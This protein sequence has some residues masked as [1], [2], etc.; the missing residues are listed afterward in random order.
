MRQLSA[1]LARVD[2]G[3]SEVIT[4]EG[5]P[6]M[7]K[8]RLLHE[9]AK[10]AAGLGWRVVRRFG[11]E[12]EVSEPIDELS[13]EVDSPT[14]V[15]VDDAQWLDDAGLAQLR[16]AG[17]ER[18]VPRLL[19]VCAFRFSPRESVIAYR[20]ACESVGGPT[21]TLQPLNESAT[22]QF[23]TEV[24]GRELNESDIERLG[25]AGGVPGRIRD[26]Y[27]ARPGSVA[28]R[29]LL[30]PLQSPPVPLTPLI[31]REVE[32]TELLE[33][34]GRERLITLAGTGGTGKTRLAQE[35]AL[36]RSRSGSGE[37]S[38]VEL[39][40][41]NDDGVMPAIAAA[42]GVSEIEG[43]PLVEVICASMI[44]RSEV[45]VVLDNA[46][47]VLSTIASLVARLLAE[48]PGLRIVCT[49]REP[50]DIR[51]EW[52]WRVPPLRLPDSSTRNQL[53]IAGIG[54]FEAVALFVE[55]A[56]RVRRGFALTAS[57][58][59]AV[60]RICDR[61]DGLPLA[62]ELAAARVRAMSPDRIASDLETRV[63]TLVQV[64][65][66]ADDRHQTLEASI[67]WSEEL[68]D[69]IERVVFRRLGVFV[70]GFTLEAAQ[71]VVADGG[72]AQ[73]QVDPYSV[74][75]VVTRLV[76]KSLVAADDV[77]DRFFMLETIRSFATTRLEE[78][79]E[80][81]RVRDAHAAWFA[82]W[83]RG[84]DE[85]ANAND[86]QQ[87]IDLTP[88]WIQGIAPDAPNCYAAFDW[89]GLGSPLSLRLTRGLGYYWLLTASYDESMRYGLASL[90][91]GDA[92]TDEW[93]EAARWLIGTLRN[94]T[95]EGPR[96]LELAGA[97]GGAVY[98]AQARFQMTGAL[99]NHK[100]EDGPIPEELALFTE[101]RDQAFAIKDWVSFTNAVYIPSSVCAEVGLL[102]EAEA[103]LGGFV[104][105]RTLL[106]EALCASRR[107]G[108]RDATQF[109]AR[110]SDIVRLDFA[111]VIVERMEVAFTE[112]EV[113]L[114]SGGSGEGVLPIL[115][116]AQSRYVGM[117]GQLAQIIEGM[118]HTLLG[119]LASARDAFLR[120]EGSSIRIYAAMAKG[121]LAQVLMAVGATA[122]ARS[123]AESLLAQWSHMRAPFHEANGHTV[124]AECDMGERPTVA[125]DHAH[126]ALATAAESELW[127]VSID[128]LEAIGTIRLNAG[129]SIEGARL[130][131]A[132]Q[133]ERDRMGYRYRFAH[134]A[135]YVGVAQSIARPTL[136]WAE[137]TTLT[138]A[139]AIGLAQ[140]MRG[141]RVRPAAGWESL[142]PTEVQV[143]E[144]VVRG[145]SNPQVAEKLFMSR[146]TVKTHLVHI[147]DKLSV[148]NRTELAAVFRRSSS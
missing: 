122:D 3:A 38:W 43:Q 34:L 100:L 102:R 9:L 90:T 31:G 115:P 53:P 75:D 72:D 79:G 19:I 148:R 89:V 51:G 39:A 5:E 93:G 140:R 137:G 29:D 146:A 103:I 17:C 41:R 129:R 8:S 91:A 88:V 82:D 26:L 112:S 11:V 141:E 125:L 87:F 139:E 62:I 124:L 58:V 18:R 64:G 81:S 96:L 110:A 71:S 54:E 48:V 2:D 30:E 94:A 40:P 147:F 123:M 65:M 84:L 98:S 15:I 108:F 113:A 21:L 77:H 80:T 132:A 143:A 47:H 104:N 28:A 4:V 27:E 105:H 70:G 44:R 61:L 127:V 69:D 133:A 45:V 57:N 50:L 25:H 119:D 32:L 16:G 52:V 14:L 106:I 7:G 142:T 117:Y 74:T 59:A 121:W 78:S 6:G 49:S 24:L 118:C 85:V 63:P 20:R 68:L 101:T 10:L 138:L 109:V 60:C 126:Q 130:L 12:G 56:S 134:R 13:F 67:A 46:E 114:L 99:Q 131:G 73:I 97:A 33:L 42:L 66:R 86:A 76:D 111:N 144:A 35:L 36:R 95:A 116:F 145:L 128:A 107:G 1:V 23:A 120:A 136:G 55:R 83:L 92:A 22:R 37:V 135:Q